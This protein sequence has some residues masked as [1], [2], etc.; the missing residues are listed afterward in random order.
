VTIRLRFATLAAAL[1]ISSGTAH[2]AADLMA[3]QADAVRRAVAR[4][5]PSVVEIR[6]LGS[7]EGA[8]G[9]SDGGGSTTGLIVSADGYIVSSRLLFLRRPT[10]ILVQLADGR[11]L[12]A[13]LVATDFSRQIVLLKVVAERRLPVPAVAAVSAIKVGQ[14]AIAVGRTFAPQQTNLSVGIISAVG[15]IAGKVMQTDA[16]VSPANYGGPL[17]DLEGRVLGVLVPMT[18][19]GNSALAGL[20]WYDSGIGFAVP[21]A[22][23][24]RVL[25][26]LTQG[27]DLRPGILG[28][29]LTKGN[30]YLVPP[31]VA[32]VLPKSPAAQ[33]GLQPGDEIS[34]V[35]AVTVDTHIRFRR[36]IGGRYA[37]DRIELVV[38]RGDRDVQCQAV[39]TDRIVPFA[40]AFIGVLPEH[41]SVEGKLQGIKVRYVYPDSPAE[42][43]GVKLGDVV[44]AVGDQ[45]VTTA[46]AAQ[47]AVNRLSAGDE[48]TLQIDRQG[49]VLPIRI[50]TERLPTAIP[51]ELPPRVERKPA[52]GP[53]PP[54]GQTE[55]KLPEQKTA[56]PLFVPE[57]YDPNISY[58]VVIWLPK[59]SSPPRPVALDTWRLQCKAHDLIVLAPSPADPAGWQQTDIEQIRKLLAM[60]TETYHVDST[61][62]VVYGHETSGTMAYLV[63]W[64]AR[65][66]IRGVAVVDAP[67]PPMMMLRPPANDPANRLAIYVAHASKARS[68]AA[69]QVS[70]KALETARYPVTT[71]DLGP[72]PRRLSSD[73]IATLARWVDSLDRL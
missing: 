33:A 73:E 22:D 51:H 65:E 38:R 26:K 30:P 27:T 42:R 48:A 2:A 43:A 3:M 15:R 14:S 54:T 34:R 10:S 1:L 4:V 39:L 71:I 19:Q 62:V 17:V 70:I 64:S 69:I 52:A 53:R 47:A 50:V 8:A 21:L 55:L 11:R 49:T 46:E 35:D 13:E 12:P 63:A 61:R 60:V 41:G 23:I 66:L 32:T 68:T 59:S 16:K 18:P 31:K 58:G 36:Q 29:S 25:P 20:E 5:S 6:T 9:Q 72:T 45:P 67:L 37:G 24:Q 40:H 28:V 57:N 7:S 56:C 44:V